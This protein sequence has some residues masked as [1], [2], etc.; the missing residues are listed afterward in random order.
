MFEGERVDTVGS[1]VSLA[2]VI[3]SSSGASFVLLS[4]LFSK[5]LYCYC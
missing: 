3:E 5:W 4:L 1:D 2:A